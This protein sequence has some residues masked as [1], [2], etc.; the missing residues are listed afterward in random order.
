M[1]YKILVQYYLFYLTVIS[2]NRR[3]KKKSFIAKT[4][5][6]TSRDPATHVVRLDWPSLHCDQVQLTC[7]VVPEVRTV[8]NSLK[9]G[10][11]TLISSNA[12]VST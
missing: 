6:G 7:T 5:S 10:N 9:P 2:H 8:T 12:L 3:F 4:Q 11:V 1:P